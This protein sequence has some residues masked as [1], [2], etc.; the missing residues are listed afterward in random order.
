VGGA[1]GALARV[2][3]FQAFPAAPASWPW[4][5]FAVNLTGA[6]ILGFLLG[7]LNGRQWRALSSG[8]LYR[9]LGTGFCSTFTTFSTVQIEL[10]RMLDHGRYGFAAGYLA[11]SVLG[12]YLAVSLGLRLTSRFEDHI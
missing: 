11:A 6:L 5:T 2:G 4:V 10:L 3:L 9:L 12:G 1:I 7:L 8:A